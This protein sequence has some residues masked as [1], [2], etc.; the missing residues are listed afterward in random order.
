MNANLFPNRLS[1][2]PVVLKL[3]YLNETLQRPWNPATSSF[4]QFKLR[5]LPGNPILILTPSGP[6]DY[7]STSSLRFRHWRTMIANLVRSTL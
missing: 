1:A 4:N 5:K 3:I 7:W 6:S 2:I